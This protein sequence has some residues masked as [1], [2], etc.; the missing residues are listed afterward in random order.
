MAELFAIAWFIVVKIVLI[1]RTAF[2]YFFMFFGLDHL[3]SWIWPAACIALPIGGMLYAALAQ[4]NKLR[5]RE[6]ES[7]DRIP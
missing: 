3:P 6:R 7:E 1:L 2:T 4:M 5:L